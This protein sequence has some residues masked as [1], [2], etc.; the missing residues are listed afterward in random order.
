MLIQCRSR[1]TWCSPQ[2][3][4][5]GSCCSLF[6]S[7]LQLSFVGVFFWLWLYKVP[8]LKVSLGKNLRV[9]GR[10]TNCKIGDRLVISNPLT[11][12]LPGSL[13]IGKYW[14]RIFHPGQVETDEQNRENENKC[15]KCLKPWHFMYQCTS[16]WVCRSCNQQGDRMVDCPH[17]LV[18]SD[19]D[20]SVLY[21][22][23]LRR[24]FW[25]SMMI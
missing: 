10:L 23:M 21:M 3:F 19:P 8:I 20:I 6:I 15:H 12:P 16:D 7:F 17:D 2:T 5:L 18:F 11:P 1:R 25:L 24:K 13:Q 22:M 14:E 9:D 4:R